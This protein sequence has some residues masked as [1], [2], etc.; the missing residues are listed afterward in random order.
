MRQ[1]MSR[2]GDCYDSVFIESCVVTIKTELEMT[3]C[4]SYETALNKLSEFI[5]Y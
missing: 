3:E 1:G 5:D 4:G 2:A